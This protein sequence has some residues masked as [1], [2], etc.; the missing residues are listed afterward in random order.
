[1]KHPMKLI[2]RVVFVALVASQANVAS[3]GVISVRGGGTFAPG[4]TGTLQIVFDDNTHTFQNGGI[5]LALT[6]D[7]PGII[8]FTD[9][10]IVNG[11]R[12]ATLGQIN[13]SPNTTGTLNA[14]SLS[15][16]GLPLGD[17]V[18]YAN[19]GYKIVSFGAFEIKVHVS[20]EDPLFDGSI[21]PFGADVSSDYS[22]VSVWFDPIPE[23][24]SLV[25][26]GIGLLGLALHRRNG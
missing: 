23:P 2:A 5:G 1:M 13:V 21:P 3:A 17:G 16:P 24:A 14:F 25:M 9:A 11:G 15:T 22:F 7:R 26:A 20:G 12:W 10:T 6:L 8:E 18:V 19:V 4:S